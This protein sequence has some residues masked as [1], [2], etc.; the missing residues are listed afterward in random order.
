VFCVSV[1]VKLTVPLLVFV[2]ILPEKAI[3]EMTYTMSG[4]TLNF[5][6][7]LTSLKEWSL[8][9]VAVLVVLV[10]VVQLTYINPSLVGICLLV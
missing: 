9:V 7:S 8:W 3:P 6:H 2:C 4:G 10:T 1:K 5:T